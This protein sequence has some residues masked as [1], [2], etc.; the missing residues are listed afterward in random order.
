EC[1]T[2]ITKLSAPFAPFISD[3]L[4]RRLN[5]V[6]GK[7]AASVHLAMIPEPDES[8]IDA[9]LQTRM[10]KAQRV[11]SLVRAIRNK[12]N[13]KVRQPLKRII[14]PIANES[15]RRAVEEMEDVIL[16]EVNVKKIE[17]V[18]DDSGIV[19]K[20]A[21]P[22]FKTLGPKYGKSVQAVAALIRKFG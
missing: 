3:E 4:F 2:T 7:D 10:D 9:Q 8:A 11:S 15:D 1:L 16:D 19:H 21:K 20:S 14:L 12:A 17:S 18:N 6:T 22:N 5:A 13:I